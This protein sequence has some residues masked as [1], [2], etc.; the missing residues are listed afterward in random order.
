MFAKIRIG[1]NGLNIFVCNYW[2]GFGLRS[3]QPLFD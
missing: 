2:V 3:L 1:K